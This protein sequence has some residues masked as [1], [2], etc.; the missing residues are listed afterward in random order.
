MKPSRFSN[1]CNH[2]RELWKDHAPHKTE[3][4]VFACPPHEGGIISE[5]VVKR[6]PPLPAGAIV[7]SRDEWPHPLAELL[8]HA[9]RSTWIE[10]S[11]EFNEHSLNVLPPIYVR[12]GFFVSEPAD[13]DPDGVAIYALNV[14]CAGRF[15]MREC[16]RDKAAEA[17]A[18]LYRAVFD[19]QQE[20]RIPQ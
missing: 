5:R 14:K 3:P 16:R 19:S 15:F 13:H 9:G 17:I 7:D 6:D 8:R 2:C 4:E 20:V 1:R 12:G 11:E 18:D 10:V